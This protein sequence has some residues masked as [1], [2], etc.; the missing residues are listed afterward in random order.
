[1]EERDIAKFPR[2]VFG[3]IPNFRGAEKAA[4]KLC[5]TEE[6]LRSQSI[7]ANPDSPQQPFREQALRDGKILIMV[8]PGIRK[9]FLRLDPSRISREDYRYASTIKGSFKFGSSV[10]PSELNIDLFLAGSVAVST[11]GGR[12]GKGK[13]YTDLEFSILQEFVALS[14]E[15]VCTTVHDIQ[16]LE[17]VPMDANDLPVD[18][19]STPQRVI[20]TKTEYTNLSS[21]NWDLISKDRIKK[22]PLLQELREE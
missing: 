16:L 13:G 8:T 17:D 4:R 11:E 12:L 6:Y 10:H 22:I 15:I 2:P 7:F 14:R 5:E 21:L 20:R 18:L 9:G 1:M 19:I 3:R